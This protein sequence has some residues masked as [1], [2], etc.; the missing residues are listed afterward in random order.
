[1]RELAKPSDDGSASA[2]LLA[3]QGRAQ[4]GLVVEGLEHDAVALGELEQLSILSC[5]ASV[6]TSKARRM[7]LKPTGAVL[8]T[9]SV[10]RKSRSPSAF[11]APL[12]RSDFKRGRDGFQRHAGAGDERLEQHVARAQLRADAAGSGMQ[13]RDRERA[14]GLDLAGDVLVIELALRLQ[15]DDGGVG[16]LLYWSLTGPAGREA[17][18][19]PWSF[20]CFESTTTARRPA[21]SRYALGCCA[22]LERT[23]ERI[24]HAALGLSNARRG[25]SRG[26]AAW[27]GMFS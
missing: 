5:G 26:R 9:P 2:T 1:M 15:G 3:R 11:T 25:L 20:S 19:R 12:R 22:V 14:A 18:S 23:V 21:W 4:L 13:A 6:S 17:R 24:Q 7:S 10:P 27:S 16:S 8:S